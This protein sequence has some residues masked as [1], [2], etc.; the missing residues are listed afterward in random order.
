[1]DL[2]ILS[3]LW[4]RS[5]FLFQRPKRQDATPLGMLNNSNIKTYNK[6]R[7]LILGRSSF[8]H[9]LLEF[10]YCSATIVELL[11]DTLTFCICYILLQLAP[12][13]LTRNVGSQVN[14]VYMLLFLYR[15]DIYLC[16]I[17]DVSIFPPIMSG[18]VTK[19]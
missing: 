12:E 2:I 19:F 18:I 7:K 16:V 11:V 9:S 8:K 10:S 17:H 15:R 6:F 4:V 13:S 3:L 5:T 14:G 1:M